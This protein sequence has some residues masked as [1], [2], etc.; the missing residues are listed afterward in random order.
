MLS[1]HFGMA[2]YQQI[3]L[4][5]YVDDTYLATTLC[6]QLSQDVSFA[7][8]PLEHEAEAFVVQFYFCKTVWFACRVSKSLFCKQHLKDLGIVDFCKT[9]RLV[10]Y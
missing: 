1:L 7:N 2:V 3:H 6:M 9:G 10:C 5:T 4:H 8:V